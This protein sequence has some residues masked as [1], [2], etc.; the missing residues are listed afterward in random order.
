LI[1]THKTCLKK[2][3]VDDKVLEL[4]NEVGDEV[5]NYII[6][7]M[8]KFILFFFDTVPLSQETDSMS[9]PSYAII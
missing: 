5:M 8:I 6:K 4:S 1:F 3:E 7:L 2:I 9:H